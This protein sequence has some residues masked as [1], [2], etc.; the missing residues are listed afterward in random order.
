MLKRLLLFC[1][2]FA[3]LTS[4]ETQVFFVYSPR[5][6]HCT[7]V[8]P[9]FIE[10]A[11]ELNSS[12]VFAELNV[13]EASGMNTA[14]ILGWSWDIGTPSVYIDSEL[15]IRGSRSDFRQYLEAKVCEKIGYSDEFCKSLPDPFPMLVCVLAAGA[16][17][18][19]FRFRK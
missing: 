10:V 17:V 14:S 1:L 8:H 9:E 5:C 12:V 15:V 2:L 13:D 3:G 11:K 18:A 7:E 19:Y 4:A 16:A 6:S